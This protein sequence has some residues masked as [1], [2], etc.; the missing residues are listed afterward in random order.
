M[1]EAQQK[2]KPLLLLLLLFAYQLIATCNPWSQ[3]RQVPIT[4]DGVDYY[5]RRYTINTERKYTDVRHAGRMIG[6][7]YYYS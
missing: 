3:D 7:S 2:E 5:L 1:S 6:Y 4:L